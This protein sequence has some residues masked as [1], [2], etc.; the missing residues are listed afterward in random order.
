MNSDTFELS[1]FHVRKGEKN[2]Q[3]NRIGKT[4][5][6]IGIVLIFVCG[7][8]APAVG[9]VS[10][11]EEQWTSSSVVHKSAEESLTDTVAMSYD[12]LVNRYLQTAIIGVVS[13]AFNSP[14]LNQLREFFTGQETSND[15]RSE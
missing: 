14:L 15:D 13:F 2:M 10:N 11:A 8:F 6:A 12:T 1:F 3:K 5:V 9:S 4:A 7:A